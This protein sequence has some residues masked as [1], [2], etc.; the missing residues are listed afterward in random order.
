L[1][2]ERHHDPVAQRNCAYLH[3]GL[4]INCLQKILSVFPIQSLVVFRFE[5]LKNDP[6]SVCQQIFKRIGIEAIVPDVHIR[7]N[8]A[9]APRSHL[10]AKMLFQPSRLPYAK[11]ILRK[12]V[13]L[14]IRDR[15]RE[16]LTT[17]NKLD[18]TPP[19][20][21]PGTRLKLI[22]FFKPYN[23]ELSH[24]LGEDLSVWDS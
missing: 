7:H 17:W 9:S 24:L 16:V 5:S 4:Y 21:N 18:M 11:R 19:S 3:R 1:N 15:M 6:V 23:Q 20:M 10:M 22:E 12:F 13:P 8:P 14:G 2:P